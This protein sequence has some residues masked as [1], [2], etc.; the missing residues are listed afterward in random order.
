MLGLIHIATV[1][2]HR[3][4]PLDPAESERQQPRLRAQVI[5]KLAVTDTL[6]RADGKLLPISH[7]MRVGCRRGG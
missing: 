5:H 6:H 7:F 3:R 2:H 1:P 4:G